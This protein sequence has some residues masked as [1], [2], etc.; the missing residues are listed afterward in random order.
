MG[1]SAADDGSTAQ[2]SQPRFGARYTSFHARVVPYVLIDPVEE[3]IRAL[4]AEGDPPSLAGCALV[5][6]SWSTRSHRQFWNKLTVSSDEQVRGICNHPSAADGSSP[7]SSLASLGHP[8]ACKCSFKM[9][10]RTSTSSTVRSAFARLPSF[11]LPSADEID[12]I[13]VLRD[14]GTTTRSAQVSSS[15]DGQ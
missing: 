7:V 12:E 9:P 13:A 1:L 14:D 10:L 15:F 4:A 3:A 8:T 11:P 5:C 6:V 2:A